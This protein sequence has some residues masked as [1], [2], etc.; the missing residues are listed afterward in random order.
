MQGA[1]PNPLLLACSAEWSKLLPTGKSKEV[2]Y[3][4]VHAFA[5]I[6][7][8]QQNLEFGPHAGAGFGMRC[9]LRLPKPMFTR[10]ALHFSTDVPF[11]ISDRKNGFRSQTS[12]ISAINAS[13][14]F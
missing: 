3:W 4:Q 5:D 14:Y 6:A 10:G 13:A 9:R 12:F 1:I 11:L 2:F 7:N 8:Q